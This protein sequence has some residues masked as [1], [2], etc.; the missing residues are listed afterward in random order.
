MCGQFSIGLLAYAVVHSTCT[1]LY[2][3][4]VIK[5][6]LI[7]YKDTVHNASRYFGKKIH[8]LCF[9]VLL[10]HCAERVFPACWVSNHPDSVMFVTSSGYSKPNEK[11]HQNILALMVQASG[12]S[13]H[14]GYPFPCKVSHDLLLL[15]TSFLK[16]KHPALSTVQVG[17]KFQP[18]AFPLSGPIRVRDCTAR[19]RWYGTDWRRLGD[20]PIVNFPTGV[21]DTVCR[22]LKEGSSQF[23]WIS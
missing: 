10:R 21:S 17:T 14:A 4:A 19:S 7:C 5:F 3:T 18:T 6:D 9:W 1:V 11:L 22:R 20:R 12:R 2:R 13:N 15:D 8:D 23:S 16:E